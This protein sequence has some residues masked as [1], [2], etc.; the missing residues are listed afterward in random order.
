MNPQKL[1]AAAVLSAAV[2]TPIKAHSDLVAYGAQDVYIS[3][4]RPD[5]KSHEGKVKTTITFRNES[6]SYVQTFWIDYK[7]NYKIYSTIPPGKQVIQKT[8][9]TH[10]WMVKKEGRCIGM[11]WANEQGVTVAVR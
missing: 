8:Y 7:G 4:C 9:L 11:Y 3:A 10:P 6:A 2:F 1:L 5:L